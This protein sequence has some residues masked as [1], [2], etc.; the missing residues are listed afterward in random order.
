MKGD[1][2]AGAGSGRLNGMILEA[3]QKALQDR[4][5]VLVWLII[6]HLTGNPGVRVQSARDAA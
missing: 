5:R 4:C 1:R 6:D 2:A 3:M